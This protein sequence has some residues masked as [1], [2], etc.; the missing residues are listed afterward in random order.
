MNKTTSFYK[1]VKNKKLTSVGDY[2]G[3]SNKKEINLGK[4]V[5]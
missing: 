1:E 2:L 4:S 3:F 5:S